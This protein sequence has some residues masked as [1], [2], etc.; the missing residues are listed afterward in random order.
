PRGIC[1]KHQKFSIQ[2][3]VHR[4]SPRS[5]PLNCARSRAQHSVVAMATN[6]DT[7]WLPTDYHER[8]KII[9]SEANSRVEQ[10]AMLKLAAKRSADSASLSDDAAAL[11]SVKYCLWKKGTQFTYDIPDGLIE[12]DCVE[13]KGILS[14]HRVVL[15]LASRQQTGGR[16]QIP[17]RI[18]INRG[19]HFELLCQPEPGARDRFKTGKSKGEFRTGS[20]FT[21][22]ILVENE[23]YEVRLNDEVLSTIEHGSLH[24][25]IHMLMLDGEAEFT[26]VEFL[27][28]EDIDASSESEQE[29]IGINQVLTEPLDTHE[30]VEADF[31]LPK[32]VKEQESG[33]Q[34]PWSKK[35]EPKPNKTL[36]INV[37]KPDLD[38]DVKAPDVDVDIDTDVKLKK[39]DVDIDVK[40]PKVKGPHFKMPSFGLKGPKVKGPDVDIDVDAPDVDV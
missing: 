17:L 1:Q 4:L 32:K 18:S 39:P 38:I 16:A 3:R 34:F 7:V 15:E 28:I 31:I 27:D 21:V 23:R 24:S 37:K 26:S 22:Q 6:G 5:S 8:L 14:G 35:N 12:G 2:S 11:P 29:E 20:S 13:I 19:G 10:S 30:E 36:N 25:M 33:V 9:L 40:G